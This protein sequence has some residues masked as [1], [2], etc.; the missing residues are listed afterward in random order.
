[1]SL[2]DDAAP[3]DKNNKTK[4]QSSNEELN[5]QFEVTRNKL[6]NLPGITQVKAIEDTINYKFG[7]SFDFKN[8]QSLNKAMNKLFEDDSAPK[9][10]K[11]IVYFEMKGNQ[12]I[13]HDA[14]DSK[15][16]LGKSVALSNTKGGKS[17]NAIGGMDQVFSTVTY[18]TNYEFEN[19]IDSTQNENAL[20][21][22]NMKKVTLKCYPFA[23]LKD[24][25]QKRCSIAN[26]ITF[27]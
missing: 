5:S 17:Q 15:S 4:K 7:V 3:A 10:T 9:G 21:S 6:L 27:K 20:L 24:S 25:T 16:I 22:S 12:L 19:K 23:A 8:I 26:I 14:M 2:F 11:D 18:S 1:M 13:R